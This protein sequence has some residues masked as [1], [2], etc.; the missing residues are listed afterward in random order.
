M[1][2]EET[3]FIDDKPENIDAAKKLGLLTYTIAEPERIRD[4]FNDGLLV[5]GA[6]IS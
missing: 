6:N 3:L 1:I 5:E 4:I 2:P